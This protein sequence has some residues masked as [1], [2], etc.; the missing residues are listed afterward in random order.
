DL[1]CH[2]QSVGQLAMGASGVQPPERPGA[3]HADD[4]DDVDDVDEDHVQHHRLGGVSTDSDGLATRGETEI[5]ADSS[6]A[7][8]KSSGFWYSQNTYRYPPAEQPC[9]SPSSSRTA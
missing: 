1:R 5:A 3:R 9:S 8:T 4:V 2:R 7:Y 6:C